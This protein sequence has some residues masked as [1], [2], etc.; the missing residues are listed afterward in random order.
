M[1]LILMAFTE[2][3]ISFA[4][5]GSLLRLSFEHEG[6]KR[7]QLFGIA[8]LLSLGLAVT[9]WLAAFT[10][11][12]LAGSVFDHD[13][14]GFM[15][16]IV[17]YCFL[18]AITSSVLTLFRVTNRVGRYAVF[19]IARTVLELVAIVVF[20]VFLNRGVVGCLEALLLSAVITAGVLGILFL[21]KEISFRLESAMLKSY[22]KFA[23]PMVVH[24]QLGWFL[25]SYDKLLMQKHFGM[26]DLA[27]FA[28]GCQFV[29]VFKLAIDGV[30]KTLNVRA[31]SHFKN[32]DAIYPSIVSLFVAGSAFVAAFFVVYASELVLLISTEQYVDAT[33]VVGYLL[34]SRLIMCYN[35]VVV[36]VLYYHKQSATVMRATIVGA[37]VTLLASTYFIP[38][39]HYLGACYSSIAIYGSMAVLLTLQAE[40]YLRGIFRP[41]NAII[42]LL[43]AGLVALVLNTNSSFLV[44][45]GVLVTFALLCLA[46][47]AKHAKVV[48]LPKRRAPVAAG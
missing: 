1:V 28:L 21:R 9:L 4:A 31:Y 23:A 47:V 45:T 12:C 8:F 39:Y 43:F 46:A 33:K 40:H 34:I 7:R 38:R 41:A 13:Y 37:L 19:N 16:Y 48:L 18:F 14:P 26:K 22:L 17:P 27:I 25:I 10:T 44:R 42:L 29:A 11:R 32:L 35:F 24:L 20:V 6:Q 36:L 2:H 5:R 15:L 30:A 3:I